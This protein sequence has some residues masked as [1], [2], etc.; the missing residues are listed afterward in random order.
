VDKAGDFSPYWLRLVEP[1]G[2]TPLP[3]MDPLLF[4]IEF[5][6]K[7]E[8]PSDFDCAATTTC[9]AAPV[10]EPDIDYLAKDFGSFKRLMSDRIAQ[11]APT[12]QE[13]N[14]ADLG[15]VLTEILAYAA[16][17]LSYRQDALASEAYLGTARRRLSIRRHARLVD[18]RMHDGCNAR[19][20][21]HVSTAA[22][23]VLPRGTQILGHIPGSPELPARIKPGSREHQQALRENTPIVFETVHDAALAPEL[24]QLAF[25]T[26]GGSQCC[27]PQGA[28]RATLRGAPAAL[29]PGA[30]LIFQEVVGPTTGRPEDAD[31]R[32]R[33]VVRLTE[34]TPRQDP[35]GGYF[36]IPPVSNKVSA[37]V[38]V[39]DITWNDD[40]ALPFPL[41][42]S[43]TT[44][45]DHGGRRL[46]RV[47]VAFGNVVLADHGLTVTDEAIGEVPA[48]QLTCVEATPG[49]AC[50]GPFASS[51][52]VRFRPTLALAPLTQ[53]ASLPGNAGGGA[54]EKAPRLPFDPLASATSVFAWAMTDVRPVV[55]LDGQVGATT[56]P[57]R[58]VDELLESTPLSEHF[59]AEVDDEGIT[60][61]RF[62]DGVF[63]C[64]PDTGTAFRA[65]YRVGNGIIGNVPAFALYHVVTDDP[66]VVAVANPLAASGGSDPES[67]DS[68]RHAAPVA[69]RRQER[70]VTTADWQEIV[71]R[72]TGVQRAAG[73]FRWTGSWY[74]V[75]NTVDRVGGLPV[76]EA[77]RSS[78]A[79]RLE[80]VR[81]VGHDLEV[82][83]PRFVA[84]DIA[85]SV[86][87]KPAYFRTDIEQEL[88]RLF[89][90]RALAD[91]S[92]GMFHPDRFTFGQ[93]VFL[94]PLIAAAQNL[95]GVSAVRLTRFQRFGL[96]GQPTDDSLQL[97]RIRLG[98]LEIARLDDDP[99]FPERGTFKLTV[100]G[101]R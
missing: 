57:W 54:D 9:A 87:V 28:T 37:V 3:G 14:A 4:E 31:P 17:H 15:V 38:D 11:L 64:R 26:W 66:A 83:A 43:A 97:G 101:G 79:T 45:A 95:D 96:A 62:G 1:D 7:V 70:A 73:T 36:E 86:C 99:N 16:D 98:P 23:T 32:H 51:V 50:A 53:A 41:C 13:R 40:D 52:P 12:W 44:D 100:G 27:L 91:G 84:L 61:L 24:D 22:R 85:M 48:P 25:Y 58:A 21:V 80:G 94:S 39:C 67:I 34:V 30:V 92:L 65:R 76:D 60:T 77:Y 68:V 88:R 82:D 90:R 78:L 42:L 93:P 55:T 81:V 63:G 59:V 2:V 72:D 18:Y 19:A 33:H 5:S 71:E 47:C 69:F 56:R 29:K 75:F 35:L 49:N 6:F 8:C 89:S 20:W 46:D 10:P 74:T